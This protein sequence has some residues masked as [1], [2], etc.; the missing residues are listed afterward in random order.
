MAFLSTPEDYEAM[1]I[2]PPEHIEHGTAQELEV[3]RYQDDHF[4]AWIQFGGVIHCEKGIHPHGRATKEGHILIGT[5][6][7]GEPLYKNIDIL[8]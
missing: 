2:T 1:G 7:Q 4:H 8:L 5:D 3:Q 6:E